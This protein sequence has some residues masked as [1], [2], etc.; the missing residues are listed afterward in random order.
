MELDAQDDVR[1]MDQ[2]RAFVRATWNVKINSVTEDVLIACQNFGT[3]KTLDRQALQDHFE[4][5]FKSAMKRVVSKVNALSE[6]DEDRFF[7]DCVEE[8]GRDLD[9]YLVYGLHIDSVQFE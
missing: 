3:D 6:Y 4:P 2:K 9:G 1:T 8:V 5:M 7:Y